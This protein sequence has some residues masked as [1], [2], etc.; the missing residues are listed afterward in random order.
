MGHSKVKKK[1][2]NTKTITQAIN[3]SQHLQNLKTA[4]NMLES[5]VM[6]SFSRY[7]N[8]RED[9]L[10]LPKLITFFFCL[11]ILS[12]GMSDNS[13][14]EVIKKNCFTMVLIEIMLTVLGLFKG[15]R[16][17]KR[18]IQHNRSEGIF[19]PLYE[20]TLPLSSSEI[21]CIQ[22]TLDSTEYKGTIETAG[23]TEIRSAL[24]FLGGAIKDA[25]GE[26]RKITLFNTLPTIPKDLQTIILDY[27]IDPDND[28]PSKDNA[29]T[30]SS[31]CK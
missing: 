21:R 22:D 7:F 16:F 29:L 10:Y 27:D 17:Y 3:S 12:P 11:L 1:A 2:S 6:P 5:K 28:Y 20:T 8:S 24:K 30:F 14:P 25:K 18:H 13:D 26:L 31:K 4:E 23:G 9:Q 15:Y 19:D